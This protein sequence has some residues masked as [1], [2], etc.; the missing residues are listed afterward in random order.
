[1]P[2]I[3]VLP[4]LPPIPVPN[5]PGLPSVNPS[6]HVSILS[7]VRKHGFTG[8]TREGEP[9]DRT[10]LAIIL[11]ESGGNET[12][13]NDAPCSPSGDHAVGLMQICSP[14]HASVADM[15]NGDKNV[16]KGHEIYVDA[17]NSF[18]RDWPSTYRPGMYRGATDKTIT[19]ANPTLAGAVTDAIT[20][21]AGTVADKALGPIDELAAAIFSPKTWE[22][23]AKGLLGGTI[24]F[25]GLTAIAV[26]ALKPLAK[27][28]AGGVNTT[29]RVVNTANRAANT[30][31]K[32][33]KLAATRAANKATP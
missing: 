27:A 18:A 12:V 1:M 32:A 8:T 15:K 31:T 7:L 19:L 26:I 22:R 11:A 2:T 3:P 24:I 16:A 9:A 21:A 28:A 5:L 29:S 4:P 20:G 14:M 17:G 30:A 6:T 13:V 25:I 33:S 23:F 10:A